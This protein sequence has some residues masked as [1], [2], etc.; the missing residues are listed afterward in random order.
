V[1]ENTMASIFF[2]GYNLNI[3]REEF[4]DKVFVG[5]YKK[6]KE[7]FGFQLDKS[8]N[9]IGYDVNLDDHDEHIEIIYLTGG[10]EIEIT[11]ASNG[12]NYKTIAINKIPKDSAISEERVEQVLTSFQDELK[13][14]SIFDTQILTGGSK[15]GCYIATAVYGSYDCAEVWVLRRYRDLSLS[16]SISGRLFI[17]PYYA[18]SP[19]LVQW[20]GKTELVQSVI[21]NNLDRLVLKLERQGY[22][23]T[24]YKD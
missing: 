14:M 10:A 21:R 5:F 12:L 19:K 16:E 13:E 4:Y 3:S 11:E 9:D 20:F 7:E 2:N 18:I 17:K 22:E 15:K 24:P 1:S 8:K 6:I 23:N